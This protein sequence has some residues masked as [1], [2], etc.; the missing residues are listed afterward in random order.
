MSST[1]INDDR[2][3][4]DYTSRLSFNA[5][6]DY[7]VQPQ[8][9]VGLHD[10]A[11]TE[12]RTHSD[13]ASCD[14]SRS[15]GYRT[16]CRRVVDAESPKTPAYTGGLSQYFHRNHHHQQ[17]QQQP[18]PPASFAIHQLLGLG[19]DIRNLDVNYDRQLTLQTVDN[20]H[21]PHSPPTPCRCADCAQS[22]NHDVDASLSSPSYLGPRGSHQLDLPYY[23]RPTSASV[24]AYYRQ[25]HGLA[26]VGTTKWP[27]LR[28]PLQ[29]PPPLIP[30]SNGEPHLPK[31]TVHHHQQQQQQQQQEPQHHY[32]ELKA[33]YCA[34]RLQPSSVDVKS[35]D[36]VI[37]QCRN[38]SYLPPNFGMYTEYSAC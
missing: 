3:F 21:H 15:P 4:N 17:Q 35:Y 29:L 9:H 27:Y 38:I 12:C 36:S 8:Y 32:D 37:R 10:V 31:K 34:A 20:G 18:P 33:Y 28:E 24:A 30:W 23:D 14:S 22:F 1:I 6:P 26:A 5:P 2:R 13:A 7:Y 11:G 16:C 25:H 19:A